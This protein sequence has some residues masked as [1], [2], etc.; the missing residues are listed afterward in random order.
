MKLRL[1]F[2]TSLF[3]SIA[4]F[5]FSCSTDATKE[6]TRKTTQEPEEGIVL[7]HVVDISLQ[8]PV[9]D[10]DV[11][12][13]GADLHGRTDDTGVVRFD[14]S[15]GDYFVDAQVCCAGPGFIEYHEGVTVATGETSRVT[16]H[17]CPMCL[18]SGQ[19]LIEG[20]VEYVGVEGGCWLIRGDDGTPYEPLGLPREFAEHG[21]RVLVVFSFPENMASI[22]QVGRIA[23]IV[24]IKELR[25]P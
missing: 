22:C 21:T 7:V 8:K 25:N 24:H 18:S 19:R 6:A 11:T 2:I 1:L 3:M 5:T 12:L 16:L 14:V 17:A 9:P 20:T 15:P 10:V 23:D 4:L 13:A